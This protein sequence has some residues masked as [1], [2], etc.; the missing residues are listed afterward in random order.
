LVQDQIGHAKPEIT[1]HYVKIAQKILA[2]A[3]E[4]NRGN[5]IDVDT[6]NS[7]GKI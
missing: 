6:A 7:R 1:R 3:F 4:A 2:D 5:A